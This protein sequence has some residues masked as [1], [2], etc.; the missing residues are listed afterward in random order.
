MDNLTWRPINQLNA[1]WAGLCRSPASERVL[2]RLVAAEP[3]VASLE[4]GDL[5]ELVDVLTV[6]GCR[7]SGRRRRVSPEQAA[8]ALSAMLRSQDVDPLIPRAILQAVLPGLVGVARRLQ[9]GAGGEWRD[10]GAFFADAATTAWEVIVEW[11]GQDRPYAVLDLLSAVRCRLRR[12]LLRY[13]SST[14]ADNGS[15]GGGGTALRETRVA[16][17]STTDLEEL[18]R[19][20]DDEW[21]S[22]IEGSDAAI[23]YAHRVLGYSIGEL[24]QLT[25]RSR[26]YLSDG[27]KRAAEALTG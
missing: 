26:R 5:A 2:R 23:L 7:R 22:G 21:G 19:A 11:A 9:W 8:A 10:G 3:A 16:G 1:D 25:G 12:Q 13:K 15:D 17:C 27:R 18:A 6:E 4:V 20:I 24:A 14:T